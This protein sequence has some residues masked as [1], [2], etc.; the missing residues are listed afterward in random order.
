MTTKRKLL[1]I[2]GI[3]EAKVEKIK[4]AVQKIAVSWLLWTVIVKSSEALKKVFEKFIASILFV[5]FPNV[6]SYIWIFANFGTN[7]GNYYCEDISDWHK[8]QICSFYYNTVFQKNVS[9]A[10]NEL[11]NLEVAVCRITHG[12]AIHQLALILLIFLSSSWSLVAS[13]PLKSCPFLT[14]A[15]WIG[16]DFICT[17]T[18]Q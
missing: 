14:S 9:I 12:S 8:S 15:Q 10:R 3:S 17:Y 1:Q 2:K 4:E 6:N 5:M 18:S 11:R 7:K 13:S 16:T